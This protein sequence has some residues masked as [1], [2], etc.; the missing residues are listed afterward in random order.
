MVYTAQ[1]AGISFDEIPQLRVMY[2]AKTQ[3]SKKVHEISSDIHP[4]LVNTSTNYAK[5]AGRNISFSAHKGPLLNNT[6][7]DLRICMDQTKGFQKSF[8][9]CYSRQNYGSE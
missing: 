5:L 6:A 2:T 4:F 7:E 1:G 8:P 9:I 3:I